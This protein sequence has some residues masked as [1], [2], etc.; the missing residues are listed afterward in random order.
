MSTSPLHGAMAA[1]PSTATVTLMVTD[2]NG[3]PRQIMAAAGQTLLA[4]LR[5]AYVPVRSVCG[6]KQSCGTCRVRID[7]AW[8]PRLPPPGSVE[9]NLLNCLKDRKQ[10][11]RL[12]CQ[13]TLSGDD[14]GLA[15]SLDR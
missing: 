13:I 2:R 7:P 8:F 1:D 3:Q 9:T 5:Q 15:V 14:S 12:A 6:G 11:D 10:T 4:A